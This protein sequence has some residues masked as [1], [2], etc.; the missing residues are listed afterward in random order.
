[1]QKPGWHRFLKRPNDLRKRL[2][3]DPERHATTL[4]DSKPDANRDATQ[5]L[6]AVAG[7]ELEAAD[8]KNTG[9]VHHLPAMWN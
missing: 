1:M 7:G 8:P 2:A 6:D 4:N 9:R 3:P 5:L